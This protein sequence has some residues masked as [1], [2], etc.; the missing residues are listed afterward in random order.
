MYLLISEL[1][2]ILG[3]TAHH[4]PEAAKLEAFQFIS[5]GY[6][7]VEIYKRVGVV[8]CR[9]VRTPVYAED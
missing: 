5:E 7:L 3:S 2:G 6:E 4:D 8:R 1:D 9:T